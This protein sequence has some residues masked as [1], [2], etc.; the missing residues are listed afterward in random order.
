MR[1]NQEAQVESLRERLADPSL[2]LCPDG[3]KC[4]LYHGTAPRHAVR[5]HRPDAAAGWDFPG[6]HYREAKS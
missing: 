5:L 1:E 2:V 3:R 4:P 6:E